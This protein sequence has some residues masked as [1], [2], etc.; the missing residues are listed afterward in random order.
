MNDESVLPRSGAAAASALSDEL[1]VLLRPFATYRRLGLATPAEPPVVLALRRPVAYALALGAVVSLLTAGRI[2]PFHVVSVPL[3][4]SFVF[5][6]QIG[7]VFVATRLFA[8]RRSFAHAVDLLFVGQAPWSLLLLAVTGALLFAPSAYAAFGFMM[9]SG[10]LIGGMLAAIAYSAWLTLACYRAGLGLGWGRAL[11]AWLLHYLCY[12]GC[13]VG[14][15][16]ATNQIQSMLF[17]SSW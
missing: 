2:V 12:G 8:R 5:F 10:A 14:Y 6:L 1:W 11:A 9:Q 15:F 7:A 4:W 13:I 16:L 17:G 3:A